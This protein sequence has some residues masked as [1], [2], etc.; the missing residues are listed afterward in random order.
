MEQFLAC[1]ANKE[2]MVMDGY[3]TGGDGKRLPKGCSGSCAQ[4]CV[5]NLQD[6]TSSYQSDAGPL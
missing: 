2:F 5:P 1:G 3:G 4:N 6:T